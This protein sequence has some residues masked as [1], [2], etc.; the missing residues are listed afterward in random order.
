MAFS[1]HVF[2]SINRHLSSL[3]SRLKSKAPITISKSAINQINLL[4]KNKSS[5][6]PSALGILIGVKRRGCN[7]LSYTLNYL[8]EHDLTTYKH[9]IHKQ[10]SI[11]YAIEPKSLF[12]LAGTHMDYVETDLASEFSFNN[13][14]AK[15]NC[16]CGES[17]NV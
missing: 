8:Y 12:V 13:P 9:D 1:P 5:E 17:F 15:G 16:G 6:T 11:T 3:S 2:T 10:G 4:L 7:G 14:H